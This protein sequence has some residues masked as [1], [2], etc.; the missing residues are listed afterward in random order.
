MLV[1]IF[2][3]IYLATALYTVVMGILGLAHGHMAYSGL[4]WSFSVRIDGTAG[5]LFCIGHVLLGLWL[6]YIPIMLKFKN[7]VLW[8]RI[9]ITVGFLLAGLI[10]TALVM[11]DIHHRNN[12]GK[13][14][15][16]DW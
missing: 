10:G 9:N 1:V 3:L 16:R 8:N 15:H 5:I 6:L 4:G 14:I 12:K 2:W 7:K 13:Y 11:N